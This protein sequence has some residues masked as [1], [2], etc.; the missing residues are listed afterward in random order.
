MKTPP[1]TTALRRRAEEA[2][3]ARRERRAHHRRFGGVRRYLAIIGPGLIVANAGNDAGGIF[4]Y[5]NTGAKYGLHLLWTFVPILLALIVTQE[6]V[7][8]LGCVTGKGLMD[9]IRERFGVRWTLFASVVVIVANG[10]TVLAEF[11]GIGGALGLLG[12][13]LPVAVLGSAA[14]LAILVLRANRRLVERVFLAMGLTFVSYIVT[15]FMVHPRWGDVAHALV[16]PT[17]SHP[18]LKPGATSYTTDVITL[19]GTTITPYMQLFLQSSIVDKGTS[20]KELNYAR[21]DVISGSTFAVMVAMFIVITT[22]YTLFPHG[23]AGQDLSSAADAAQALRPLA[24]DHATQLF[25][26]GLLG[27]SLLAAAVLPLSTAFVVC[28]AFGAERSVQ[29]RFGEAP[30][31]FVLFILLLLTGAV[32]VALLGPGSITAV[33]IGTQTLDGV[34]L[35]VL[36]VFILILAND[37]R[38]LGRYRNGPFNNAVAG[39]FTVVLSGLTTYLVVSTLTGL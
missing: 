9:L 21:A 33:A 1:Q 36:L 26:V 19:I 39:V 35:P 15:A 27:A 25:A 32:T 7:A 6:M 12:V 37:R 3:A 17:L 13:P 30:L 5:S 14:M 11:A 8:R 22:A 28:E 16:V 18:P 31:F 23:F 2:V 10:G 4:T 29:S 38:L 34:L 24:G 20:E